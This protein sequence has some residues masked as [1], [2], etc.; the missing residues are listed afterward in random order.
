MDV[1]AVIPARGGSKGVPRK[2]LRPVGGVPL[3]VR[4]IL[5]ARAVPAIDRVIVSTDD[6]AIA[7]IAAAVEAEVI[8]R[9]DELAGDA[10]SSESAL[11]HALDVLEARGERADVLV[12]LQATSPFIDRCALAAAIDRVRRGDDDC[13]FSATES[14]TFLWRNTS[15]GAVGINHDAAARTR[16]Q[17]REAQYAETGAFYVLDVDG[18]RGARHRFFGRIGFAAVDPRTA[19]EIDTVEELEVASAIAGVID[20]EMHAADAD[21][22]EEPARPLL[23][24]SAPAID[25]DAVVAGFGGVRVDDRVVLSGDGHDYVVGNRGDG[26]A[27]ASLADAEVPVL[28]LS[29]GIR[30]VVDARARVVP[31]DVIH[32]SDDK[33]AAVEYWAAEHGVPLDRIAYLG[34][35]DEDLP[36]LRS[37]G[38]PVAAADAPSAVR[39]AARV[40]LAAPGGDGALR[41]LTERILRERDEPHAAAAVPV[42]HHDR[43]VQEHDERSHRFAARR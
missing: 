2:N 29:A 1:V 17:D 25:V 36:C 18:F 33:L 39:A 34:V 8:D 35:D 23:P 43:K 38:W 28:L 3:V 9:P 27:A 24:S 6:A 20:G 22:A 32:G 41:E 14:Y 7:R 40:V 26:A 30:D 16:R 11:L 5:A 21:R 37:V 12:F 42:R 15:Q 4:A 19:I 13:V 31:V 10:A